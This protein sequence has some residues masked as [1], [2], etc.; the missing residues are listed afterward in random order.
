[1]VNFIKLI[2]FF[3]IIYEINTENLLSKIKWL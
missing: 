2:N 1:M 3:D